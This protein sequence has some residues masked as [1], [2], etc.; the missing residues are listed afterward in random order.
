MSWVLGR[1]LLAMLLL[2]AAVVPLE[3]YILQ[4]CSC[5]IWSTDF[6]SALDLKNMLIVFVLGSTSQEGFSA[7]K[8]TMFNQHLYFALKN[9]T[10]VKQYLYMID[11]ND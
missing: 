10:I 11:S 9:I 8:E 5:C 2:K 6:H 3:G 1:W 7:N 4:I